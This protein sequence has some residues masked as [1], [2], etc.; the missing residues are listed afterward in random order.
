MLKRTV[1]LIHPKGTY[2]TVDFYYRGGDIFREQEYLISEGKRLKEAYKNA[3][4]ANASAKDDLK[5]VESELDFANQCIETLAGNFGM[6]PHETT[7]HM[8]IQKKI[9]HLTSELDDISKKIEDIRRKASDSEATSMRHEQLAFVPV[10]EALHHEIEKYQ[11]KIKEAERRLHKLVISSKY[12]YAIDAYSEMIV[13]E[14]TKQ[15]LKQTISHKFSGIESMRS[16]DNGRTAT[17]A[18]KAI[19]DG[20]V[21]SEMC[22]L[23]EKRTDAY[24]ERI[25]TEVRLKLAEI[26]KMLVENGLIFHIEKLNEYTNANIQ[27]EKVYRD[28]QR[29]VTHPPPKSSRT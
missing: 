6:E 4:S 21:D 17:L 2:S 13:A 24:L 9:S 19:R 1:A 14:K 5:A 29:Q 25:G 27:M 10:F 18:N 20:I 28:I 15:Y 23:L 3:K 11:Q 16:E 8:Q 12:A 26:H 7:Q 22:M